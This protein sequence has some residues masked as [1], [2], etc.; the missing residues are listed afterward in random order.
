M[1]NAHLPEIC[2]RFQKPDPIHIAIAAGEAHIIA[3][4][5]GEAHI[6]DPELICSN[7]AA[8]PTATACI[9]S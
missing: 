6:A 1:C 7:S 4:A 2:H 8:H 9:S 3:I 5:A